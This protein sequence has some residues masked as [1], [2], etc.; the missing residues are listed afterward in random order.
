[1]ADWTG[2]FTQLAEHVATWSKDRSRKVGCVIV[3]PNNEI[4]S[5]GYNGFPRGVDD[6]LDER[7]QRPAKYAWT[8]HA[9]RNAIYNAARVGTPLEGCTLYG[10]LLYPCAAC[11]RAIIQVGIVKIFVARPNFEDPTYGEEFRIS[12]TMLRAASVKISHPSEA[13]DGHAA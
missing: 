8:E 2:R 7:H 1:M 10:S 3:G 9:E 12:E 11:A 13:P 5:T 6:D 4:R